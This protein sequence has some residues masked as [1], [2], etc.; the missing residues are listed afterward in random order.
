MQIHLLTMSS[1]CRSKQFQCK[2][3]SGEL[4]L[5]LRTTLSGSFCRSAGPSPC[6]GKAE[7]SN[8]SATSPWTYCRILSTARPSRSGRFLDETEPRA[9]STATTFMKNPHENGQKRELSPIEVKNRDPQVVRFSSTALFRRKQSLSATGDAAGPTSTP[10]LIT[11]RFVVD[12]REKHH[13]INRLYVTGAKTHR[14]VRWNARSAN[15]QAARS[16]DE[17]TRLH[18]NV[19]IYH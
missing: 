18:D 2:Q 5:P 13:K 1:L 4:G 9:R 6:R 8:S 16:P 17:C 14:T 7:I 11:A 12:T 19:D 3:L 15:P 10:R